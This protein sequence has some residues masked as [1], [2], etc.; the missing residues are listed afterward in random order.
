MNVTRSWEQVV[1]SKLG[2]F[3]VPVPPARKRELWWLLGSSLLVAVS[4]LMVCLAKTQNFG[5]LQAG[6]DRGELLDLNAVTDAEQLLPFLQIYTN[7]EERSQV[8]ESVWSY[9]Q[10][11]KPVPNVGALVRVR[12]IGKEQVWRPVLRLKPL[13]VVRTPKEVYRKYAHCVGIYFA[14]FLL[15]HLEW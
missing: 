4:L 13:F 3:T 5:D 14:A 9:L 2:T 12:G 1:T 6:L 10:K 15:V 8:A 7:E 11:H